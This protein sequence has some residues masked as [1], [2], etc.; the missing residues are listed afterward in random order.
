MCVK[1]NRALHRLGQTKFADGGL[2]FG[3]K[4][5]SQLPHLPLKTVLNFKN[6]KID[7]KIRG[8]SVTLYMTTS[9]FVTG[10]IV[11]VTL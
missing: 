10:N 5:F 7:S 1:S 4:K 2:I 3:S 9:Y 11:I 8:R 6:I